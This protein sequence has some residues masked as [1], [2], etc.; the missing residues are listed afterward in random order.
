MHLLSTET[1]SHSIDIIGEA[2]RGQALMLLNIQGKELNVREITSVGRL[3]PLLSRF[4]FL[5]SE[6]PM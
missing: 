6:L 4:L 1:H 3:F 5:A 2:A